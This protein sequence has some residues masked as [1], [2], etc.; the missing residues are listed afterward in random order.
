MHDILILKRKKNLFG[1]FPGQQIQEV[2]ES[3][4]SALCI[5]C[6]WR[7]EWRDREDSARDD[8]HKHQ[9]GE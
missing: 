5:T 3:I 2:V 7:G 1:P 6:G 9:T 4:S 8:A